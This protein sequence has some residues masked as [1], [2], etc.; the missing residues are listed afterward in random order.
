MFHDLEG[1]VGNSNA[2]P[3]IICVL[4]VVEVEVMLIHTISWP[5]YGIYIAIPLRMVTFE[6]RE[7]SGAQPPYIRGDVQVHHEL[8]FSLQADGEGLQAVEVPEEHHRCRA[9]HLP[10][11]FTDLWHLWDVI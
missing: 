2:G 1:G 8:H 6:C 3:Y 7:I 10:S 9:R 4:H 5:G 11:I